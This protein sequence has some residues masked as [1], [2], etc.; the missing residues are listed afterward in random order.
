MRNRIEPYRA[1]S[2]ASMIVL[3]WAV[4]AGTM[5]AHT[6]WHTAWLSWTVVGGLATLILVAAFEA[7]ASGAPRHP[8]VRALI[9]ALAVAAPLPVLGSALG[10][11]CLLWGLW[12]KRSAAQAA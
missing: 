12:A 6:A 4:Y 8:F 11:V 5:T 1:A 9:A 2:C 3:D 7:R 10:V